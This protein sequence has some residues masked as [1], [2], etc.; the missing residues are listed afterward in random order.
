MARGAE[1]RSAECGCD[2]GREVGAD[3]LDPRFDRK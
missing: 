3:A 2:L 1:I